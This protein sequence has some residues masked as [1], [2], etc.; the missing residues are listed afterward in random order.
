MTVELPA[1]RVVDSAFTVAEDG[2]R[3]D[4]A[5]FLGS[6]MRGP[7]RRADPGDRVGRGTSRSSAARPGTVP[8]AVSAFF[9]NGGAG[10][11][12]GASRP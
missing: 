11:L 6:T 12:G 9:A 4:V 1:Y 7:L 8:R 5:A 2:L 3:N 10:R